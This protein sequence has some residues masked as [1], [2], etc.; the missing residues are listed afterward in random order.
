MKLLITLLLLLIS[1]VAFC[2]NDLW[3]TSPE[4]IR[5]N[6]VAAKLVFLSQ[7]TDSNNLY[8]TYKIRDGYNVVHI[9]EAG[10]LASIGYSYD[11][12]LISPPTPKGVKSTVTASTWIDYQTKTI[13]TRIYQG[14]FVR[15]MIV[16]FKSPN[17]Q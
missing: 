14:K 2:Q 15:D 9:F 13:C 10:S 6:A 4:K 16:P 11:T 7:D 3:G 5:E 17:S 8:Q 12:D 1:H